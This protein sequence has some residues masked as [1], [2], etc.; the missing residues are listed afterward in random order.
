MSAY[1]DKISRAKQSGYSDEEIMDFLSKKDPDFASKYEKARST[2]YSDEQIFNFISKETEPKAKKEN[3][4][5]R[6]GRGSQSLT[7]KEAREGLG[8]ITQIP[9]GLLN[10]ALSP[11]DVAAGANQQ[12]LGDLY[13]EMIG[14]PG[15]EEYL[16]GR[17][18]QQVAQQAFE[19]PE[20]GFGGYLP[21]Q[22]EGERFLAEKTGTD[23]RPK[24]P[25]QKG[26]RLASTTKGLGG[27]NV[28]SAA[29]P[30]TSQALQKL[31]FS[32]QIADELAMA[33]HIAGPKLFG[34]KP[35]GYV[36]AELEAPI[37][38]PKALGLQ[39]PITIENATG[40]VEPP[41][42]PPPETAA[43]IL[44][45][46]IKPLSERITK[47]AP[48]TD[49]RPSPAK[50]TT[51]EQRIARTVSDKEFYNSTQGGEALTND[52]SAFSDSQNKVVK[53]AYDRAE[54]FTKAITEPQAQL[55]DQLLKTLEPLEERKALSAPEASLKKSVEGILER[56]VVVNPD[57]SIAG[58]KP[59]QTSS[60]IAE[61]RSLGYKVDH[62]FTNG[63]VY[64]I[65]KPTI[66][67]IKEAASRSASS[68]PGAAE[69]LKE[70]DA[71]YAKWAQEFNNDYIKPLRDRS[72]KDYKKKFDRFQDIDEF[73]VLKN[74]LEQDPKGKQYISALEVPLV[75]KV[76]KPF[77]QDPSRISSDKVGFEK[78]LRELEGAI[79]SEKV[80]EVRIALEKEA[81]QYRGKKIK[82]L[83]A[84]TLRLEPSLKGIISPMKFNSSKK[85]K[86][87]LRIQRF[88]SES[89]K[90]QGER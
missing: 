38:K 44:P 46:P 7:G 9:L 50:V 57:G 2:G 19:S 90:N 26:L 67:Q 1:I 75:E 24:T 23:L 37:P 85:S 58:Y 63:N 31:G 16:Q 62:D 68:V 28:A 10:A 76:M 51:P 61:A 14:E 72:N 47:T 13:S 27:G 34:G 30:F 55:V 12:E 81:V 15:Y 80:S 17:T 25:L 60:L 65:F 56:L 42:I 82:P 74:V 18:P 11:F 36:K 52:V 49:L 8:N 88:T 22:G 29:A 77:I 32:E 35:S 48:S 66:A 5:K 33:S 69:A 59:I 45:E 73:N 43:P 54:E 21:T 87:L 6:I 78:A 71:L 3:L 70:A 84:P 79:P 40:R 20:R 64:N 4:F 86:Q 39:E 83:G 41:R 53:R 89:S